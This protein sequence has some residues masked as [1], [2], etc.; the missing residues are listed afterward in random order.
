MYICEGSTQLHLTG[1]VSIECLHFKQNHKLFVRT[2]L[3]G[4]EMRCRIVK[5]TFRGRGG[6]G[7]QM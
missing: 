2:S 4:S 3:S 5:L 1:L 6:N 7:R